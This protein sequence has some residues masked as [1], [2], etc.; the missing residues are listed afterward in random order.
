MAARLPAS[1][2]FHHAPS[3]AFHAPGPPASSA[4]AAT[5]RIRPM[6]IS[7]VDIVQLYRRCNPTGFRYQ[8]ALNPKR[9]LTRPSEGVLNGGADNSN[10]DLILYVNDILQNH[11]T[12]HR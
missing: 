6:L 9:V 10:S 11:S 4:P 12:G 8:A 2:S 7:T 5:P 3:A 1:S